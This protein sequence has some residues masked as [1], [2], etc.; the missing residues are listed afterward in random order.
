MEQRVSLQELRWKCRRGMLELDILLNTFI[1]NRYEQL[2]SAQLQH[3][4]ELL[5]YPDQVL[6]DLLVTGRPASD[7]D[8]ASIVD[9]IRQ[10]MRDQAH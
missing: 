4:L 2:S 10:A 3:L 7:P 6:Q 8:I 5:D 1:N 9:S